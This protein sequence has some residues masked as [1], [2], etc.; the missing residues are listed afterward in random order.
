MASI[1]LASMVSVSAMALAATPTSR[2]ANV[3]N[4]SFDSLAETLSTAPCATLE[5]VVLTANCVRFQQSTYCW[6][7]GSI[8]NA[9]KVPAQMVTN[10][11]QTTAMTDA[12]KTD[13]TLDLLIHSSAEVHVKCKVDN[14][15]ASAKLFSM[16]EQA[17]HQFQCSCNVLLIYS[18]PRRRIW[19]SITIAGKTFPFI[20]Q[21]AGMRLTNLHL[22]SPVDRTKLAS[23]L[24][25]VTC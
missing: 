22:S 3:E 2:S 25:C 19:R 16:K 12:K 7:W 11:A 6:K 23:S 21:Q 24:H 18:H 17:G 15:V 20:N 5:A 9:R 13:E 8:A 14:S 1:C 10:P 4:E